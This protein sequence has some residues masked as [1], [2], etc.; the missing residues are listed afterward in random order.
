M[1]CSS[2]RSVIFYA[3]TT[4][5]IYTLSLHDALRSYVGFCAPIMRDQ[6]DGENTLSCGSRGDLCRDPGRRRSRRW[7]RIRDR[8]STRV[9]SSDG[10]ISYAVVRLN[11][12]QSA[13]YLPAPAVRDAVY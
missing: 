3:T 9:N 12:E 6:E 2:R 4:T 8:K 11:K 13:I 10:N 7:S 1:N 5:A